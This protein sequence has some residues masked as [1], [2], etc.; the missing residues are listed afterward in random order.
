MARKDF[1]YFAGKTRRNSPQQE[2][3]VSNRFRAMRFCQGGRRA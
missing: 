2:R 3:L 1:A